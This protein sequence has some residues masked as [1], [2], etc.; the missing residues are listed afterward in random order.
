LEQQ[1]L[2]AN[3]IL[4]AF[5]NAKTLRNN[6]SS[7]FDKLITVNFDK[8]GQI[9]GGNI[10]NYLLEKSRVVHQT[11]G[12]R[13]YHIF[14]Q[15]L[16]AA[17]T[18]PS[19]TAELKLQDAELFSYTGQSGVIHVEGMSDEKD[20]EDIQNSMNI[21]QFSAEDKASMLKIVAGVLHFDNVKFKV[22]QRANQ[23]DSCSVA[24]I[25]VLQHASNLWGVNDKMIE[26][27]LTSRHIGG[28]EVIL[29]SYNINQAQDTRDAMVKKVYAELFQFVVDH[30]NIALSVGGLKRHKFIGVLDIFGFESSFA[31]TFVTKSF[32]SISM[33]TFSKWNKHCMLKKALLFQDL[34]L[35]T[36]KQH[37]IYL[38]PRQQEFSPC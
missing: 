37:W 4:E 29:V 6:N 27:F 22:E 21:L 5:G 19:L 32:N 7:R 17:S 3:P 9:I 20:F 31:L 2:A 33:N 36:I 26:K 11:Q 30:I 15:L 10:I 14:Y 18:N 1:I 34:H 28:R 24:N 8:N 23:E 16:S 25:E 13:N 38:R 12:E 35:L